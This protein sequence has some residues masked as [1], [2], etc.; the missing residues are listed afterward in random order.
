MKRL[1]HRMKM[2]VE[3][4]RLNPGCTKHSAAKAVGIGEHMD[5]IVHSGKK[6]VARAINSG[7][8]VARKVNSRRFALY[9]PSLY[10]SVIDLAA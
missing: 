7:F 2:V 10:D 9:V 1:G 3:Y 8:I 6:S 5:D 4:V